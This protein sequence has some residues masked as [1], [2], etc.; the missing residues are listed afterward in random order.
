MQ[1]TSKSCRHVVIGYFNSWSLFFE[2]KTIQFADGCLLI[3]LVLTEVTF[4]I[5]IIF[6]ELNALDDIIRFWFMELVELNLQKRNLNLLMR[7]INIR[8]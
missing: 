8:L 3:S 1:V 5:D 4:K 7:F 2:V 6:K